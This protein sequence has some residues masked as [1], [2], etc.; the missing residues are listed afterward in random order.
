MASD[1]PIKNALVPGRATLQGTEQYVEKF[2]E[3]HPTHFR[4]CHSLMISSI[5]LGS[6]LGEA[7]ERA[8]DAYRDSVIR[9]V[10]S[11]C[12][13]IDSAINYRFQRSERAIGLALDHLFKS[14]FSRE[15]IVICTK[16]G[17][18]SYDAE[19]PADPYQWVEEN[20]INKAVVTPEEIHPSGHCMSPMYLY[21][22]IAQSRRNLGI[23]TIDLYYLHNPEVQMPDLN[24]VRY[25]EALEMAFRALEAAVQDGRIGMYGLA[26]WDG[27]LQAPGSRQLMQLERVIECARR[28]AGERHHFCAVQLPINLAMPEAMTALNQKVGGQMMTFIEAANALNVCVVASASLL[29]GNLAANLPVTIQQ[30]IPEPNSDASRALQFVRSTPGVSTALVGMGSPRHVDENLQLAHISTLSEADFHVLFGDR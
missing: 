19:Y 17:F 21:H 8:D 23:D 18:I 11:G 12:N 15:E 22:E 29:Q 10:G 16:G 14:G 4:L 13:I 30:A 27:F 20:L 2:E 28:A 26:T 5:G 7:T 3:L 25:Y 24:E 9:A 6:Y 1:T